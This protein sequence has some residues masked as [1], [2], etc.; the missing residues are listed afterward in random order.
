[1][2]LYAVIILLQLNYKKM[3][4]LTTKD[5][6]KLTPADAKKNVQVGKKVPM[7]KDDKAD[8]VHVLDA[9]ES[10]T[11]KKAVVKK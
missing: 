6:S 11:S 1:M 5:K 3:A 4:T 8:D 2:H 10:K 9:P 7:K